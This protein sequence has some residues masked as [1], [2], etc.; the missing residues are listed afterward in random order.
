MP[1]Y[2]Y[3]FSNE[4]KKIAPKLQEQYEEY[5]AAK[6][7]VKDLRSEYPDEDLNNFRLIYADS[8]DKA[9]ILLT[10]QR[11]KPQIEEWES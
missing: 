4:D 1:Y 11:K 6:Q 2:V 3:R 8:K 9:R 10:T 5:K 7:H